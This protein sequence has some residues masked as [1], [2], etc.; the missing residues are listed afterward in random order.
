MEILKGN[1]EKLQLGSKVSSDSRPK[2]HV[3]VR[4][5]CQIILCNRK[6]AEETSVASPPMQLSQ[7]WH[8]SP[9]TCHKF[10]CKSLAKSRKCDKQKV[11][12]TKVGIIDKQET[13]VVFLQPLAQQL[14]LVVDQSL[15]SNWDQSE[16]QKSATVTWKSRRS[17]MQAMAAPND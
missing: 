5:S 10:D 9:S 6:S 8:F 17:T 13:S 12:G 14:K 1:A 4:F 15:K 3:E 16:R 2:D 11:L 7:V